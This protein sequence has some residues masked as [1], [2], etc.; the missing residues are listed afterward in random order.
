MWGSVLGRGR[1]STGCDMRAHARRVALLFA[2][3]LIVPA[4][5]TASTLSWGSSMTLGEPTFKSG[6]GQPLTGVVCPGATCIAIDSQGQAVSYAADLSGPSQT[7]TLDPGHTLVAL[8]CPSASECVAIDG[9]RAIVFDP[10][11]P[12]GA[13]TR[14]VALAPGTSGIALSGLACP[15]TTECTS[16]DD[17]ANAY[18]FDPTTGDVAS[19]LIPPA[20]EATRYALACASQTVCGGVDRNGDLFGF[21]PVAHSFTSPAFRS[22]VWA[23]ITCPSTSDCVAVGDSDAIDSF[24]PTAP[25]GSGSFYSGSLNGDGKSISCS[26]SSSCAIGDSSGFIAGFN[27]ASPSNQSGIGSDPNLYPVTGLD[28][29]PSAC[30]GTNSEGGA[31]LATG[32]SSTIR[33]QVDDVFPGA[34]LGCA[35]SGRCLA[36]GSLDNFSAPVA[37][38]FTQQ[39]TFASFVP[40]DPQSLERLVQGF[41]EPSSGGGVTGPPLTPAGVACASASRCVGTTDRTDF[42]SSQFF[43]T[44]T[45]D[46]ANPS[47]A[48]EVPFA[49]GVRYSRAACATATVCVLVDRSGREATFDPVDDSEISVGTIDTSS[50]DIHV[51]CPT[52]TMCTII[53]GAGRVIDFDPLTSEPRALGSLPAGTGTGIACAT[54]NLCLATEGTTGAVSFDPTAATLTAIATWTS[55]G[56]SAG[57]VTCPAATECLVGDDAGEILVG[58]P[59]QSGGVELETV[60][61]ANSISGVACVTAQRCVALDRVGRI[62]LGTGPVPTSSTLPAI[63]GTPAQ[64]QLLTEERGTWSNSPT[65]FALQWLSCDPTGSNC[66]PIPGATAA[67][68]RL[69]ASDVGQTIRVQEV[70]SNLAG[71]SAPATS[72]QTAI[73]TP[74]P[75]TNT[76]LPTISGVISSGQTLTVTHGAW[77]GS[78][79]SFTDTWQRCD[80]TGAN[81]TDTGVSGDSYPLTDDDVGHAI[82][83][84]E[85]ATNAGGTSDPVNSSPTQPITPKPGS[86]T[87]PNPPTNAGLPTI[88]GEPT[89]GQQLACA[90]GTWTGTAPIAFA[91]QWQRDGAAIAGAR[92]A[93]VALSAEDAQHQISCRVTATN[94]SGSAY[95]TSAAASVRAAPAG[96]G[97]ASFAPARVVGAQVVL[98]M[99]CSGHAG[100]RCSAL[101]TLTTSGVR[102]SIGSGRMTL[103]A[104]SRNVIVVTL[105]ARGRRL[106]SHAPRLSVGLVARQ[107]FAHG[108]RVDARQQLQ[109]ARPRSGR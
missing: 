53:D 98:D 90:P 70:A 104:F 18:M 95:A 85:S 11:T 34:A 20:V 40:G 97:R 73:V 57:P 27:P 29:S 35:S 14:V 61:G 89:V 10:G 82:R 83:V 106:L 1:D 41:D 32:S 64:G 62:Y 46:P 72:S 13:P 31:L 60:P 51:A 56:A 7:W 75:P 22:V 93:R 87:A 25:V 43:D 5:S 49:H 86:G 52:A 33:E 48:A 54:A 77:N 108:S 16:F 23:A 96:P 71:Q 30:H 67:T 102:G 103:S 37:N 92:S 24:D 58:D 79:T 38:A 8:A 66:V 76:S 50:G 65:G 9:H 42:N 78:P 12:G 100:A 69:T 81:C 44:Y 6:L 99:T 36:G 19:W 21:D 74:L 45:I 3:M 80:T 39:G 101:V 84:R 55:N 94:S 63:S 4:T 47:A 26:S 2:L 17:S 109:L 59:S 105:N 28:C 107:L 91:Y 88:S 68:Y 15:A